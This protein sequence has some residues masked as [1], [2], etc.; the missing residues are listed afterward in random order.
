MRNVTPRASAASFLG[1]ACSSR[2]L[3][4]GGDSAVAALDDADRERD[5]LLGLLG[6]APSAKAAVERAPKPE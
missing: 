1:C 6:E 2:S 4:V 3:G 5:Q